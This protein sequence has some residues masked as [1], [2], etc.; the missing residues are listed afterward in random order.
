[1]KIFQVTP[2]YYPSEA[3]GVAFSLHWLNAELKGKLQVNVLSTLLGVPEGYKNNTSADEVGHAKFHSPKYPSYWYNLFQGIVEADVLHFN[4]LFFVGT[5]AGLL[6]A[7][8]LRKK[9]IVSTRG[10]LFIRA[11]SKKCRR[12]KII[13]RLMKPISPWVHFHAT[14][15]FERKVI[16]DFF[17]SCK[18]VSLIPNV[19]RP[20]CQ[21]RASSQ[22]QAFIFVGRLNP[23]KNLD[24]LIDAFALLPK[25]I[26]TSLLLL[27]E[28]R[29]DEEIDYVEA[30][31]QKIN[32]LNLEKKIR[33]LGHISGSEKLMLMN[34]SAALI[35]PS[36]SENFGNVVLEALSVGTPALVSSGTPWQILETWNCGKTFDS[37]SPEQLSNAL[38]WLLEMSDND[39]IKMCNRAANTFYEHF[40]PKRVSDRWL[41]YYTA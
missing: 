22:R 13:I 38:F 37:Q 31:K 8:I 36:H 33:F 1:M 23:I 34:E 21:L 6:P 20:E 17:P 2:V 26:K 14:S 5:L 19:F 39:Y 7:L 28:A 12:K 30:L 24:I 32:E 25:E 18:S 15:E 9:I 27:G 40:D 29:L 3:G 10:E 16:K 11:L 4:S 35:L 41:A